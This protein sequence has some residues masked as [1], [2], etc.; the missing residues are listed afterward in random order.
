[1]PNF[2]YRNNGSTAR[3]QGAPPPQGWQARLA[4][5]VVTGV[6]QDLLLKI[7]LDNDVHLLT[8]TLAVAVASLL[9]R[10]PSP[11]AR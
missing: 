5:V 8:L 4:I 1:M 3:F 6:V 10:P 11:P 2:Y 9:E 7:L